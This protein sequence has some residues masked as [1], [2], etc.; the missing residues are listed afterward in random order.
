MVPAVLAM[1]ME[2]VQSDHQ[3][4][5]KTIFKW[6]SV[7]DFIKRVLESKSKIYFEVSHLVGYDGQAVVSMHLDYKKL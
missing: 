7:P 1:T 6:L 4:E 2:I 3:H 5:K